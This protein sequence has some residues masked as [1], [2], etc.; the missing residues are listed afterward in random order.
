MTQMTILVVLLCFVAFSHRCVQPALVGV[1][2]SPTAGPDFYFPLAKNANSPNLFP[3]PDCNGIEL[4]EATIDQLQD[5]MSQGKLT[6]VQL[7]ICYLER[8]YQVDK[9]IKY[10][11]SIMLSVNSRAQSNTRCVV[12]FWS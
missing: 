5:A 2:K 10:I 3:M 6:A 9:Y 8:V 7:A 4:E 11:L 1:D 12:Q